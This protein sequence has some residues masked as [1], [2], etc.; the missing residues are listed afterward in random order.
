MQENGLRDLLGILMVRMGR[1]NFSLVLNIFCS[2]SSHELLV[3]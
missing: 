3:I 1:F 2:N